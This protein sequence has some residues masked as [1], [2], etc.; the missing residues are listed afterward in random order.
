MTTIDENKQQEFKEK[1]FSL[2]QTLKEGKWEEGENL[3][4]DILELGAIDISPLREAM[5]ELWRRGQ[6]ERAQLLLEQTVETCRNNDRAELWLHAL[7]LALKYGI[8]FKNFKNQ[9][10]EAFIKTY[11][12]CD[13]LENWIERV[14]QESLSR[15]DFCKTLNKL[16]LFQE[17]T[18]VKHRSGWGIGKVTGIGEEE[19]AIYMDLQHKPNHR[20]DAYAAAECLK[21]IEPENFEAMVFFSTDKLKEEAEGNPMSLV[22]RLLRFVD[23]PLGAKDL[24]KHLCPAVID[25]KQWSKWWPKTRKKM[26]TDAYV[27][28]IGS[29]QGKYI[30][31]ETPLDWEEEI[32]K[33]FVE[34]EKEEQAIFILEYLKNSSQK[35]RVSFFA[36]ELAKNCREFLEKNRL[37]SLENYMVIGE[38]V[39]E[40][41][42]QPEDLP[43]IE[44]IFSVDSHITFSQIRIAILAQDILNH[45]IEQ[46]SNWEEH[47]GKIFQIGQDLAR[48]TMLKHLKKIKKLPDYVD[49]IT[50]S[51]MNYRLSYPDALLWFMKQIASKRFPKG[52]KVPTMIDIYNILVQ[53][54]TSL[55]FM[56]EWDIEKVAKFFTLTMANKI[57]KAVEEN[58][59]VDTLNNTDSA[60]WLTNNFR[61]TIR[62]T[63]KER[64]P[65]LFSDIDPIY[66][67]KIGLQKYEDEYRDLMEN[68]IPENAKAIGE[69][70]SF[71]DLSENAEL[72]AARE[73]QLQLTNKATDMKNNMKR[74][75]FIDYSV[76]VK[77]EVAIG[78]VVTIEGN[79]K[80]L[81]YTILGPW[82]VA[83]DQGVI[84]YMSPIAETLIGCPVGEEIELPSGK[85]TIKS[86][87]AYKEVN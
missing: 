71:G 2:V 49:T 9:Y 51:I 85:Y 10:A 56:G 33:E 13:Y 42:T 7:Q 25:D 79:K 77:N 59:A 66:T 52:K 6:R 63:L 41:A 70:L 39:K 29:G 30:L 31:R 3:W 55:Q 61:E 81:I 45:F 83:V 46:T 18:I 5:Q 82:D 21:T 62:L 26:I 43:T 76:I 74:V 78:S 11:T 57:S 40:G 75:Q 65:K 68:K 69:A 24:K 37:I 20:M 86:T 4:L 34:Q 44:A 14:Q 48:D 47:V 60:S 73:L 67:T 19:M 53:T 27:E 38:L 17:G 72:D 35:Q 1:S 22:Y 28:I 36:E 64:F 50:T 58:E 32:Q 8:N 15:D 80:K 87:T 23:R 84:S 16:V 12:K 54:T